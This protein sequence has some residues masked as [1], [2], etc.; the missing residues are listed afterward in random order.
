MEFSTTGLADKQLKFQTEMNGLID[1]L[2]YT[3]PKGGDDLI[4]L[5]NDITRIKYQAAGSGFQL[6]YDTKKIED[7]GVDNAT[8]T[9]I[10]STLRGMKPV[11]VTAV[12][13]LL[14]SVTKREGVI[15]L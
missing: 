10:K 14:Q 7:L 2:K 9:N 13:K 6:D 8:L 5:L 1:G 4:K 11:N 12:Q 3:A 15:S